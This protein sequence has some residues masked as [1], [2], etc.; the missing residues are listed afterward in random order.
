[1]PKP[2]AHSDK[3]HATVD[4][5]TIYELLDKHRPVGCVREIVT[6]DKFDNQWQYELYTKDE[7]SFRYYATAQEA[8]DALVKAHEVD[9]Y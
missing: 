5:P 6:A 2:T 7:L 1:M 8:M 3:F 9:G 4:T